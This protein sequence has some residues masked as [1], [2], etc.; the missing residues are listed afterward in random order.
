[1]FAFVSGWVS[2]TRF[3]FLFLNATQKWFTNLFQNSTFM[4]F[5]LL[6]IGKFL[7]C[8]SHVYV[9]LTHVPTYSFIDIY[10]QIADRCWLDNGV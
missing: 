4:S 10:L 9:V 5:T 6:E 2:V 1:M 3:V 7:T 8:G